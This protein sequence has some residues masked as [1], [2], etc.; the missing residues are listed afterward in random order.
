MSKIANTRPTQATNSEQKESD[1]L[2]SEK[3]TQYFII[4]GGH[5]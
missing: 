1:R 3:A 4:G 5:Y 2:T